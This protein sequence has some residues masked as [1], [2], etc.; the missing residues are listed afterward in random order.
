METGRTGNAR[1]TAE[2]M[3]D[4]KRR[5]ESGESYLNE[6]GHFLSADPVGSFRQEYDGAA[7]K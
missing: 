6:H 2:V 4:I 5:L 7:T 3:G 1:N